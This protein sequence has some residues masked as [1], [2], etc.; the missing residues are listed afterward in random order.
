VLVSDFL[1]PDK[2][3]VM[4]MRQIDDRH[5]VVHVHV[6]HVVLVDVVA[7]RIVVGL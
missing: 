3:A 5:D 7:V 4:V 1:V 6:V 2:E